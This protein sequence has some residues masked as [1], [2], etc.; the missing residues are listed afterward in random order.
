MRHTISVLVEN[1]PGVLARISTL[2]SSRGFNIESLTVGETE[3]PTT[4]RMT[5]VSAGDD[6]QIEQ[7]T[8]QLD[9][10]VDTIKVQDLTGE[11]FIERELFLIR[12]GA[13]GPARSQLIE[14]VDVFRAKIVDVSS[15]FLTVELTG[16][17]EKID[18]FLDLVTPFGIKEMVRTGKVALQRAARETAKSSAKE[19]KRK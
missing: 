9:K 15:K 6:L 12:L 2:F 17:T 16:N 5:I 4:S 7:I 14:I 11:K 1:K 18:A 10:L 8:K 19:T 13:E 3:D